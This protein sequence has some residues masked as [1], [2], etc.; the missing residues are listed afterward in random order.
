MVIDADLLEGLNSYVS[1]LECVRFCHS[2]HASKKGQSILFERMG[3]LCKGEM[4]R[5]KVKQALAGITAVVVVR[6]CLSSECLF[7]GLAVSPD[8][9]TQPM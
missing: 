8:D 1:C 3:S 5:V 9:I 6:A 2:Q 7:A 4:N